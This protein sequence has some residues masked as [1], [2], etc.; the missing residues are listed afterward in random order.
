MAKLGCGLPPRNN[1]R[2]L[3]CNVHFDKKL[4][5]V[6]FGTITRNSEGNVL[7]AWS[8]TH[9]ISIDL[10]MAKAWANLHAIIFI[11]EIEMFYI[12]F[13]GDAQQVMN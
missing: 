2:E 1:Q 11:K 12:I 8:T 10:T 13:E 3:G 4:W 6:G 5:Q 9:S 7:A